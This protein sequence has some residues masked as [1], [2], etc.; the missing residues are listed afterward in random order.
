MIDEIKKVRDFKD[1]ILREQVRLSHSSAASV[2]TISVG[3]ASLVPEQGLDPSHVVC[4][5]IRR[6][7]R[8]SA[9]E[10]TG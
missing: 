7:T 6:C 9:T 2:V 3:A 1:D 4:L 5:W 8:P 10:A